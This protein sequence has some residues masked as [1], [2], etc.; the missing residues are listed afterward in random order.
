MPDL[1]KAVN[2]A[3]EFT[4]EDG[5]LVTKFQTRER[6]SIRSSTVDA[7]N[8]QP[9]FAHL[10]RADMNR[11]VEFAKS[12]TGEGPRASATLAVATAALKEP[13]KPEPAKPRPAS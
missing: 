2:N 3:P 6:A 7:F 13:S 4:G 12:F 11:A 8:L 9:V 1:V 10:A 5:R